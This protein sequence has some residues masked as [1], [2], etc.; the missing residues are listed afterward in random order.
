MSGKASPRCGVAGFHDDGFDFAGA[1][2][3]E[4]R[5]LLIF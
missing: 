5:G 4:R 3:A 1:V 2:A